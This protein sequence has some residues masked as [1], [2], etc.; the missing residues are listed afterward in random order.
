MYA[1]VSFYFNKYDLPPI[2]A[3]EKYASLFP[4]V[5]KRG[6]ELLHV[7]VH[8]AANL[9]IVD[10]RQP[11]SYVTVYVDELFFSDLL[12]MKDL[13]SHSLKTESFDH[14]Y[15]RYWADNQ[16]YGFK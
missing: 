8:G 3:A 12:H 7:L 16:F 6:Y 15:P 14:V 5:S 9:P 11:R 1:D 13:N 2:L 4:H 10:G